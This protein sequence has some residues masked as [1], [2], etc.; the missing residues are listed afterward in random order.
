MPCHPD[1]ERYELSTAEKRELI[2]L[3]NE[4]NGQAEEPFQ[5]FCGHDSVIAWLVVRL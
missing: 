2:K 3:I 1:A 5:Q 4:G